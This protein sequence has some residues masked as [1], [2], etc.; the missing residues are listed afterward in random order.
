M[1]KGAQIWNKLPNDLKIV[2]SYNSFNKCTKCMCKSK[3]LDFTL[4]FGQPKPDAKIDLGIVT[5]CNTLNVELSM[6]IFTRL[7]ELVMIS[8]HFMY[9][10][11]DMYQGISLCKRMEWANKKRLT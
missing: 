3:I 1:F 7:L 4:F 11:A 2:K 10:E 5:I 6:G 9:F 8:Y